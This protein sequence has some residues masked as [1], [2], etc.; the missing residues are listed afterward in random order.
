MATSDE[1]MA[2]AQE[3]AQAFR[4][5]DQQQTDRILRSAY[6][7]AMDHR[8]RLAKM[9]AEETGLGVWQDKVIKN[10]IAAQLVYEHIRSRKTAGVISEDPQAGII[11]LALPLGPILA[12]VPVINPTA[13][14]IF[15]I[16][17]CLKTR[18]PVILS[19]TATSRHSSGEAAR[20]CYQAVLAAGAPEHCIQWIEKPNPA[21]IKELM[22]HRGLA[23]ILATGS[24]ELVAASYSSG[25][26]TIGVGPGNVPVY[27]GASA[28]IPFAV[29]SILSSKTFDNGSVC[30]SE[31]AVVVKTA[32]AEKVIEEFKR[33]KAHFLSPEETEKVERIAFDRERGTMS[34]AVV[35]QPVTKIAQMAGI[36]VPPDTSVL[37]VQLSEVCRGSPFSAEILAPILA[38]YVE[39]DFES[40]IRRCEE[41]TRFGGIGHTAVIYSNNPERIE[42][43]ANAINVARILVNTPSTQGALGG[44][45]NTL[46]P[47]F[48]LS[49][50][51]GGKNST[52]DNISTRH[53][54]NIHRI[55]RRRTND[56]WMHVDPAKYL[57]ENIPGEEIEREYHKNT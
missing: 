21:N 9:A 1:I 31:Q 34:P 45:F 19:P 49:C 4:K 13:T 16:L 44:I 54:L 32:E 15:K 38:F 26:P 25:T 6:L 40:S 2:R 5:V 51:S 46:P 22:H 53:L 8:V 12:L 24:G 28:D 20:I 11:E 37:I 42:Y 18:N 29:R 30:A 39:P 33:Q 36:R 52:T 7:A 23:L 57:D 14:T 47:S 48:T 50:G 55:C 56:R 41:I 35:G 10:A 43:F 17:I 3:A 27:I